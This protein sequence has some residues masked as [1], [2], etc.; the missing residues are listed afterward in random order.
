[1]S[2]HFWIDFTDPLFDR[3][4]AQAARWRDACLNKAYMK[5]KGLSG[6]D[7][8]KK[9]RFDIVRATMFRWTQ[10]RVTAAF[11]GW[12]SKVARDL[13]IRATLLRVMKKMANRILDRAFNTWKDLFQTQ[14]SN[15]SK[16]NKA[17]RF[18]SKRFLSAAWNAWYDMMKFSTRM[19]HIKE[20]SLLRWRNQFLAAAWLAWIDRITLEQRRR[21][22]M[23]Q[24]VRRWKMRLAAEWILLSFCELFCK[25]SCGFFNSSLD[26]NSSAG[27]IWNLEVQGH[28]CTQTSKEDGKDSV[29]L[30]IE[31]AEQGNER[32]VGICEQSKFND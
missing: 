4:L 20:K 1:M 15:Q 7:A 2:T 19:R 18:W 21:H 8:R 31:I 14:I 28:E 13:Y 6:R 11:L 32:L 30:E 29:E 3:L 25:R 10:Q 23:D 22:I 16:L 17:V 5:W 27:S 9:R 12:K 24:I 26:G